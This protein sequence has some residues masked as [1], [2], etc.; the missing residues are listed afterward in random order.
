ME[1]TLCNDMILDSVCR[2]EGLWN[3]C[4][5][6]S[7]QISI[8]T[9]IISCYYDRPRLCPCGTATSYGLIDHPPDD[10]WVS[11][12]LGGKIL[13][14]ENRRTRR[15][16]CASGTLFTACTTALTCTRTATNRSRRPT[17]TANLLITITLIKYFTEVVTFSHPRGRQN[18]AN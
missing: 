7:L 18:T 9:L 17:A 14:G 16:T 4:V 3:L 11:L 12:K 13:A 8:F 1:G 6:Q 2:G 10:I 15:K 5:L